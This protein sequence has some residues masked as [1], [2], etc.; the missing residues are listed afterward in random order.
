MVF[1]KVNCTG[2]HA[3]GGRR[4]RGCGGIVPSAGKSN[5]AR[6]CG[7]GGRNGGVSVAVGETFEC[8]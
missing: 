6:Y 7:V 8:G 5:N 2:E 1:P 4:V 3:Q